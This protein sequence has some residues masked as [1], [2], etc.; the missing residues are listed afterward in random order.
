MKFYL[1]DTNECKEITIKRWSDCGY[2]PDCFGDLEINFPRT[3]EFDEIKGAYISTSADYRELVK[4]WTTEVTAWN[5]GGIGDTADYSE[6]A[7][8]NVTLFAD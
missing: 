7:D 2:E 6:C 5:N 3:H 8:A 1:K 4:W